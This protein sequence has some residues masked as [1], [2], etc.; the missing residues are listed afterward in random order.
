MSRRGSLDPGWGTDY[1]LVFGEPFPA[2][3]TRSRKLGER[4]ACLRAPREPR[5]KTQAK[6][7]DA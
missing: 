5:S 2:L 3:E 4:E 7:V 6:H 1:R